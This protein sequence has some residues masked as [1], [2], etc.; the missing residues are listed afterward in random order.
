MTHISRDPWRRSRITKAIVDAGIVPGW[1]DADAM[2]QGTRL[3]VNLAS[4]LSAT[5]AGQAALLTA[6]ATAMRCFECVEADCPVDM[7]LCCPLP[8]GATLGEAVRALG[9][10]LAE[11]GMAP[12]THTISIGAVACRGFSIRCWWDGWCAGVLPGDDSREVGEGWNSLSGIA[13]AAL[14]VREVFA[15][16]IGQPRAGRRASL[17]SLWRSWEAPMAT[18]TGPRELAIPN[19]LWMVGLGHL[20]QGTAWA[21]SFLPVVGCPLAILQDD[22]IIEPENEA[23][24]LLVRPGQLGWKKTRVVAHWLEAVGWQTRLIE[25]R[26]DGNMRPSEFEPSLCLCGLDDP[27]PRRLIAASGYQY[28]I[29]GGVGHGPNDF[30]RLQVKVVRNGQADGLWS[31]GVSAERDVEAL[32][33][34]PAYQNYARQPGICGALPLA[35]AS[36]AVPFVG[37]FAGALTVATAI[38]IANLEDVPKSLQIELPAPDLVTV[39]DMISTTTPVS[40]VNALLG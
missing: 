17:L 15:S 21:L 34:Q 33:A 29:D 3:R 26:H 10:M 37:A 1:D 7:Q 22:Q 38:R 35:Q 9:G 40:A 12:S 18:A 5:P 39:S 25:R 36:V 19:A 16:A 27:S 30:Q 24:C 32:L 6:V 23:T 14:A 11:G 8:I 13:S 31:P 2:L 28:V 4:A 20:G